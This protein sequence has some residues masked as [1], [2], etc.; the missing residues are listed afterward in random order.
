MPR[1]D[2]D[3]GLEWL[4]VEVELFWLFASKGIVFSGFELGFRVE[5]V[6]RPADLMVPTKLLSL[7]LGE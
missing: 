7:E 1:E 2:R 5:I 3:E 4:E 6:E